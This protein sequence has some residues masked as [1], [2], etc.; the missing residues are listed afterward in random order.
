ME[1]VKR[2]ITQRLKLKVNESKS[3]VAKPGERKFFGFSRSGEHN[4][5]KIAPQALDRF[6]KRVR[7]LT[8]RNRGK[9]VEQV[10]KALSTYLHGWGGY[11]GFCETRPVLA[12]LD[13]WIRRRLR[14]LLWRQW[15]TCRRRW[16]ELVRRDVGK[17]AASAAV[18][19]GHGSWKMSHVGP[20][21]IALPNA[22]F[23][24][25]ALPRLADMGRI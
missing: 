16:K 9:S 20:I 8:N 19:T 12:D 7:V 6:K 13:S 22:Y 11:F 15:K 4:R 17:D 25:L 1:S 24:S 21:Q 14:C 18:M 5:R 2:F 23:D 3:A 10:V